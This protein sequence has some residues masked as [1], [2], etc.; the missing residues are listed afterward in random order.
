MMFSFSKKYLKAT[1]LICGL[2]FNKYIYNISLIIFLDVPCIIRRWRNNCHKHIP[3]PNF[4]ILPYSFRF[5]K[6][7]FYSTKLT[8]RQF[9]RSTYPYFFYSLRILLYFKSLHSLN[10]ILNHLFNFSI[11]SNFCIISLSL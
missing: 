10:Y 3:V 6:L 5:L 7:L 9:L 2:I 8:F 1:S 11:F 4:T